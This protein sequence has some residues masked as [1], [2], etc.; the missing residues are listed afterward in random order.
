MITISAGSWALGLGPRTE[1]T[2]PPLSFLFPFTPSPHAPRPVTLG[3][4]QRCV[5]G[6]RS[7]PF[8]AVSFA[9]WE[10]SHPRPP[11]PNDSNASLS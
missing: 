8:T 2:L 9:W 10:I 5:L 6:R 11:D 1:A 4:L 3:F 7:L